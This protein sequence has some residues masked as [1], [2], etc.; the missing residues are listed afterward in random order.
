MSDFEYDDDKS[1]ANLEKHGI[2]FH[3]A[4]E[5]WDDPDLLE[6]PAKSDN[7]T[8]FIVI[9]RIAAK[10]WSAVV[11]YRNEKVRLISVRRSRKKEVEL[12]ES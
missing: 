11:T 8:R 12:Y 1:Q 10:H 9:G 6:F 4:Q 7:E 5:L 3:A 2:D